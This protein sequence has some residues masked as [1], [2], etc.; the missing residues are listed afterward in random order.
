MKRSRQRAGPERNIF[1]SVPTHFLQERREG[2]QAGGSL[3]GAGFSLIPHTFPAAGI[4]NELVGRTPWSA[5]DALVPLV[6]EESVVC[7]HRETDQEVGRGRGRPP[8]GVPSGL[9]SSSFLSRSH[10]LCNCRKR[11]EHVALVF[12]RL[13][14]AADLSPPTAGLTVFEE[15]GLKPNADWS[16]PQL[17]SPRR[18]MAGSTRAARRAGK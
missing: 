1:L 3:R 4:P 8:I 16:L 17:H 11:E 5:R 12:S 7:D 14:P 18:V 2:C 10:Y 9:L 13:Q 15:G 6:R